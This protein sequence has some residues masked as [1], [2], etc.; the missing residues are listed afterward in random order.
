MIKFVAK[1]F[2]G[3]APRYEKAL[4]IEYVQSIEEY[5]TA[6]EGIQEGNWGLVEY[7]LSQCLE[8]LEKRGLFAEPPYNLVLKRF[9]FVQ[10]IQNKKQ[11]SERLLENIITNYLDKLPRYQAELSSSYETLLMQ[12]IDSNLDKAIE[13]AK[14]L[15]A[16][17]DEFINLEF[18]K[19]IL[20]IAYMLKGDELWE[21]KKILAGLITTNSDQPQLFHN[22]GCA[23]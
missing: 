7:K 1:F 6:L 15:L 22:L 10:R 20:A 16:K 5:L 8:V 4:G 23:Q 19:N 2:S 13:L 9:A 17:N 14:Q 18:V 3:I 21:A 12:Y 11:V